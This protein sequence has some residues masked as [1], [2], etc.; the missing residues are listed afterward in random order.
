MTVAITT[1][2]LFLFQM[3]MLVAFISAYFGGRD[4][5]LLKG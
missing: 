4:I 5:L 1:T 2:T 3:A